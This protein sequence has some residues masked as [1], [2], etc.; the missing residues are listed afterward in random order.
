MYQNK[1]ANSRSSKNKIVKSLLETL[2]NKSSETKEHALR[3]NKLANEFGERLGLSNLEL[4]QLSILA[5]LHDIGKAT[6][7]KEIL[8]KPNSLTE[9]EWNIMK[10]HPVTG[11]KITSSTEEFSPIAKKILHHHEHWDG[12]G[13]P[14]RLKENE[15][16]YLSRIISIIDAYDVMTNER[17]YSPAMTKKEALKEIK[18]CAGSQFDPELAMEFID[19]MN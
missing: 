12:S 1:L 18:D 15:I 6:I 10:D 9:E 11:F 16:P 5:K 7:S 3:M 4:N 17:P 13:Y 19:F 2:S 8:T 14:E